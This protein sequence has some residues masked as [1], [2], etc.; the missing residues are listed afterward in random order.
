MTILDALARRIVVEEDRRTLRVTGK[1]AVTWLNGL[2]TCDVA[3]ADGR[4]AVYGLLLTKQGK[5][6]TDLEVVIQEILQDK[7]YLDNTGEVRARGTSPGDA[8]R[9]AMLTNLADHGSIDD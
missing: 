5:V 7:I 3:S 8:A 4:R 6:V 1:D 9:R 2:V